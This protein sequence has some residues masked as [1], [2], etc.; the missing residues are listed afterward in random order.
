MSQLDIVLYPAEVLAKRAIEVGDVNAEIKRLVDNMIETMY[1]APGIGLAAPQVD[2]LKRVTVIDVSPS[3]EEER[4]LHVMI[5]PTIVHRQGKILW[6]EGCLSIPGVYEKV[7]RSEKI[8]VEALDR[9]GRP[10]ELEAEGLLSVCIQHEIDHLDGVVF[11]DRISPLKRRMAIKKYKKHLD[12]M[13]QEAKEE[14]E[15]RED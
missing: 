11:L 10:F 1:K 9:E 2:V 8:V 3:E 13:A 14:A 5:N 6:E 7:E 15:E 12:R 4:Q